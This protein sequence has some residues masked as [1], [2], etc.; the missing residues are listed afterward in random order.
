MAAK[1]TIDLKGNNVKTDS[2]D[3]ENPMLS[4]NGLYDPS[5]V[6]DNGDV[7]SNETIINSVNVGNANIFGHVA[8]GPGGTVAWGSNGGVGS[9]D[10]QN[11]NDGLQ[12]GWVTDDSNFTMPDTSLPYTSGLSPPA[13]I[14]AEQV[15][16]VSSN[17]FNNVTTYPGNVS[18]RGFDQHLIDDHC[19]FRSRSYS[20]GSDHQHDDHHTSAYPSQHLQMSRRIS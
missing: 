20:S 17:Q 9:H 2:F 3:S 1:H 19:R 12:P 7:A 13:G 18:G 10:W 11:G 4:N 6:G 8:T 15:T 16:I 14:V 5:R